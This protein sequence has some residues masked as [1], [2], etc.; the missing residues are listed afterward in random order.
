[1]KKEKIANDVLR[2]NCSDLE[3]IG[4]ITHHKGKPFT[5]IAEDYT[6]NLLNKEF[7]LKDGLKEGI[8]QYHPN[9]KL[10]DGRKS[11][12]YNHFNS[13]FQYREKLYL[14]AHN[15][16]KKTKRKSEVYTIETKNPT[17]LKKEIILNL[18]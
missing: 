16:T 2:V 12:N 8:N 7:I 10:H 5:G 13:I 9:G 15:E 1:M 18:T 4:I 17:I 6:N 3:D 11:N 14:I